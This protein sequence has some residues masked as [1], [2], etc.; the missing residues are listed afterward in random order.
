MRLPEQRRDR[1]CI[2]PEISRTVISPE[3]Q[4]T[5][6]ID[7][8]P[9]ITIFDL[10]H[11]KNDM[12]CAQLCHSNN[13]EFVAIVDTLEIMNDLKIYSDKDIEKSKIRLEQFDLGSKES[14]IVENIE[15]DLP[16]L[17]SQDLNEYFEI[18]P[19]KQSKPYIALINQLIKTHI[20]PKPTQWKYAKGWTKSLH[21]MYSGFTHAQR[22]QYQAFEKD[23][24]LKINEKDNVLEEDDFDKNSSNNLVSIHKLYCKPRG[25]SLSK[26]MQQVFIDGNIFHIRKHFQAKQFSSENIYCRFC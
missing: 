16:P 12:K 3:S 18:I 1:A 21:I 24:S 11:L 23:S 20:L 22:M 13:K 7:A 10:S 9:V 8:C 15:F 26:P 19:R 2:R 25:V 4:K 6:R 17:E 5:S 14:D